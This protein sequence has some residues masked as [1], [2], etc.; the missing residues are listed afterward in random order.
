MKN[1]VFSREEF[2]YLKALQVRRR[3]DWPAIFSTNCHGDVWPPPGFGYTRGE[4]RK[5]VRGLSSVIDQVAD[6]YLNVR[7]D[8]GPVLH[9]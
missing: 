9:S 8:G 5:H 2:E 3:W 4:D 6:M 7:S 1:L